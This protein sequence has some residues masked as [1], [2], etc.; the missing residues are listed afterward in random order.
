MEVISVDHGHDVTKHQCVWTVVWIL[1]HEHLSTMLLHKFQH[2]VS[3][4][5]LL[6][7]DGYSDGHLSSENDVEL[8][9]SVTCV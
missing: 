8:I 5:L 3:I 7:F 9:P 2:L 6:D 4:H 1:W